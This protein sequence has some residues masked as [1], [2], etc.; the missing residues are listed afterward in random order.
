MLRGLV[1]ANGF[2]G[3]WIGDYTVFPAGTN[4]SV[5]D[6]RAHRRLRPRGGAEPARALRRRHILP[7]P[8]RH[9][10]R[11]HLGL[12]PGCRS[13]A[14]A[15]RIRHWFTVGG[16]AGGRALRAGRRAPAAARRRRAAR[17]DDAPRSAPATRHTHL[18][19]SIAPSASAAPRSCASTAWSRSTRR[20][21]SAATVGPDAHRPGRHRVPFPPRL[22]WDDHTIS[23]GT[24]WPGDL[25]IVGIAPSADGFY[26]QWRRDGLLGTAQSAACSR[27]RPTRTSRLV[28]ASGQSAR[29]VLLRRRAEA[30]ASTGPI[31]G[32]KT[33]DRRR[34]SSPD[35]RQP[36]G[37]SC[38]PAAAT[39]RPASITPR[40]RS[41]PSPT[42]PASRGSTRPIPVTGGAW[43]IDDIA[44][45]E[46]GVRHPNNS[47]QHARRPSSSTR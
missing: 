6:R 14:P 13:T 3:G 19:C 22:R 24:V 46:V 32:L 17:N 47:Q 31:V 43:S 7:S 23:A 34:A 25:G 12:P 8:S 39:T 40:C 5:V 21:R 11:R 41:M 4:A 33:S 29:V 26:Q 38:A 16:D 18:R 36:A 45:T 28:S 35:R 20:T 1:R 10:H 2:E 27:D 9:L 44:D 42:S 15:R 37:S 30:P